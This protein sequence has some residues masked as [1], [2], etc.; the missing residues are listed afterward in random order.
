MKKLAGLFLVGLSS[1]FIYS[2]DMNKN[3]N[4][5]TSQADTTARSQ[6]KTKELSRKEKDFLMDAAKD[7]MLEVQ[8]GKLAS[9]KASSK[10]VKEF[11]QMMMS[12][13]S[14][15]N[16][17]IKQ[18][19]STNNIMLPDSLDDDDKDELRDMAKLSGTE[20]DKKFMNRMVKDH[21]E[22][23]SDFEDMAEKAE[24]PEIRNMAQQ[25]LPTLREHYTKAQQLEEMVSKDNKGSKSK[26]SMK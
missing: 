6:E 24:N 13:H 1:L 10:E 2:C 23:V 26:T 21:K 18:L 11:G 8:L 12:D 20:F 5:E 16:E 19:A 14:Q 15:A 22:D 25:T 7:G 9:Q 17:K 4:Q 3:K